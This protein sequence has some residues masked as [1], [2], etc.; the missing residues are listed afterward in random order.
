MVEN[1]HTYRDRTAYKGELSLIL[2]EGAFIYGLGQ[3]EDGVYDYRNHL[4]YLYQHN[5]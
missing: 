5:M 1:I 2:P 3:G 4:Q